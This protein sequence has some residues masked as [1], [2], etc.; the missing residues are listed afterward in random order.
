MK[1]LLCVLLTVALLIPMAAMA[2]EE[3]TVFNWED[4]IDQSVLDLFEEETGIH[5]NYTCF[6]TN[7]EMI[8]SVQANPGAYDVV[9]PSEYIVQRMVNNDLLAELNYDNIPNFQYIQDSLKNPSYD[10]DNAHS[11]PY[12]AGTLGILYNPVMVDEILQANGSSLEAEPVDSWAFM[13]DPRFENNILMM[14]SIRDAMAMALAYQ[15]HSLNST[16]YTELR[17]AAD[18]LLAQKPYVKAYGLDEFKDKMAAGEAALA[19]VY[20]GDA[21]YAIEEAEANGIELRYVIPK[22]G[23]NVWVDCAVIPATSQHKEA[24]EAFINFL[25]R[26]DVAMMNVQEIWY[27]CVNDAA[28]ELMGEEYSDLYVLNPTEEELARC[29]YYNDIDSNWLTI[30][31]TLWN[32]VK[33]AK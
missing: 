4:Y 5:V 19:L 14:D 22:E 23:S 16:D 15:G 12:M 24:A 31:D 25:C 3:I 8:I 11:V 28:I 21:E 30:Y 29:E 13:W 32:E 6:T 27:V 20:S 9:I 2:Q 17:A 33:S 18:L 7:E 26:P 1:K 10:P